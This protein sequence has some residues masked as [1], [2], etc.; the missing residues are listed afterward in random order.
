[1]NRNLDTALIRSFVTVAE[2]A[3]MTAAAN[4]LHLTQGAISQ[5]IKR[6]EETFECALFER[7]RRGLK[8]T[9]AGERLLGKARRLLG[10]NDEIWAEL[11]T[12]A[13]TGE[14][15]LGLPYDLVTTYLPPVLKTY[16]QAFPQ[17]EISLV[18]LTSPMLAEA[19]AAGEIDLAVIEEPVGRSNGECLSIERLVW[20]GCKGGEAY[21][22]RPLPISIVSDTCAFRPVV[23]DALRRQGLAWRS[24]YAN[25][26]VEA[27]TATVMTD[28]AVTASLAS[29]VP[30]GL[31]VLGA[32]SGLPELASFAI[33][34]H[35]PRTDANPIA[36]G[37][38]RHIR[39]GF[40]GRRRLMAA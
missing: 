17:V 8:L 15:K 13:F 35:L 37:L 2:T 20:V 12:P 11:T 14:I 23:F 29:T 33:N 39:D 30:Y 5:Q 38:A 3:S 6:L 32:D 26:S 22:K 36:Q 28:L 7:D 10:L 31:D 21:M 34:L 24:V 27:I 16:A 18:C 19:L 4:A 25:G 40:L 1:M 9:N